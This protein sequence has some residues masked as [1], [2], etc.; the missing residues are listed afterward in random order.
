MEFLLKGY[1]EFSSP[2]EHLKNKLPHLI[3]SE[4]NLKL[5]KKGVPKEQE[6]SRIVNWSIRNEILNLEIEGTTY[7]RPHD[8]LLRLRNFFSELLG[9]EKIGVRNIFVKEYYIAYKPSKR[10][11]EKIE[12]KVPWVKSIEVVG[13]NINLVLKDLDSRALEDR[14]VERILKR[15]EEKISKQYVSGKGE[16]TEE[17]KRSERKIH[18]YKFKQ[19]IT[20]ILQKEGWIKKLS[21]AGVWEFLPPFATLVRALEEL[22]IKK[23]IK[24]MNFQEIFLPRLIPFD[25][26]LKKGHFAISNEIFWV[27]PPLSRDPK[28]IEDLV[29][30]I[31]IT[32]EVPRDLLYKKLD[33]P[34]AGLAYAQCEAFYQI[35]EKKVF[36]V[37]NPLR[38]FDRFGPTWRAEFG[39]V[40]GLERLDEFYRMELTYIGD[41]NFI[42]ETRDEVRDRMVEIT[43]KILDL[44]WRLDKTTPIYLE[45]AGKVE[46]EKEN[47]VKTYD[48]T[49]ILPFETLSRKERELE[50]ASFHIHKDFYAGRFHY[51]ERKNREIWTGCCGLGMTRLAYV[52]LVRH[53]LSFDDWPKEIKE[54]IGNFPSP[55]KF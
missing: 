38:F 1:V 6:A 13:N 30:Y 40:R 52:F 14:Y 15:I 22:I 9:K 21:L 51:K 23:I 18:K 37:E 12:I 4:I 31:E 24:P 47:L 45:H 8:A 11:L 28:E 34:I 2:I 55:L 39:G 25:T 26:E 48:L 17:V 50:I 29:D 42:V 20:E 44:E 36:N 32:Q 27:C 3:A 33:E 5:L 19:D 49:I 46:E 10:P 53:G 7:L 41:P 16:L 43:D 54:I 35:F